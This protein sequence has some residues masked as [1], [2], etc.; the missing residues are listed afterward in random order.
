[1]FLTD[2][3]EGFSYSLINKDEQMTKIWGK[4]LKENKVPRSPKS[5]NR[6][7]AVPVLGRGEKSYEK[8]C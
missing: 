2:V 6:D 5:K 4:S 1:M 7:L 8:L 3:Q